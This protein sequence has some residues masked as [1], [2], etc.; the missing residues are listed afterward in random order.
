AGDPVRA[1]IRV[2]AGT[3]LHVPRL[4]TGGVQARGTFGE[5]VFHST[6]ADLYLEHARALEADTTNGSITCGS[7]TEL[8]DVSTTDGDIVTGSASRTRVRATNG[9]IRVLV[10][11]DHRIR[12]RT[13][14][15][16]IS[17]HRN[18]HTGA[19]V[20]TSTTNGRDRTF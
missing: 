12:A 5:V 6:T 20:N 8:V 16:D 2:P 19:Q 9:D 11:G 14:N 3:D 4:H 1:T 7:T 18:G 15:G 17:V 10:H 13:T